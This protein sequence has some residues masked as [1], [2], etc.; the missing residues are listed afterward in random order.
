MQYPL[1]E[2]IGEPELFVGRK[3]EFANFNKWLANIP[4]KLSKSRAII[5]RRKSGK[6]AFVQRLFNQLWNENGAVIPFYFSFEENKIWYPDLAIKY[7]CA[8]ASQYISFQER[9]PKWVN[10]PLSLEE[11]KEY[12]R[13]NSNSLLIRDTRFIEQ[14]RGIGGNHSL[15]WDI[16]CSAPHRFADFF[17]Q[18]I[19]VILD[20]FQYI[21]QFVYPDKDYKNAPIET[22]AGSYH[23]LSESKIAPMLITGSYAGLLLSI[24]HEY[25]EA[26]RVKQIHFSPY[27]TTDEGLQAVYKYA[28]FYGEEIT[29]ETAV[30]INELCLADPFF[31][32]CVIQSEYAEKNLATQEGVIN[33]VNYEIS[34]SKAEMFL[35]WGEYLEKTL[36]R[37]NNKN[38][39]QLLLYLNKHN[40]RYWTPQQLKDKIPLSLSV[41]E[42]QKELMILSKIDV[43]ERGSSFIDFRGLQD[44]TL[45]LVLRRCFEKE[46]KGFAPNFPKEF[47]GIIEK[48]QTEN[49]S[50]RG[51]LSYYTGIVGEHLLATAFRNK[52]RFMLSDFFEN[53]TDTTKL[54][55]TFVRER[56]R[57]QR[58]NGKGLEI[59][60]VA[61]SDC[62]RVILVEVKKKKV[63]TGFEDLE[64]FLEKVE[65][66]K[67]LFPEQIVLPAFLSLGDFTKKAK[68]YCLDMGIGMAVEIKHV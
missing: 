42:I 43:I 10:T 36:D 16:V 48:L 60:L 26:G 32:Y 9:Q 39:K 7:Y 1:S 23:S 57:L 61:E 64:D 2:K 51:K 21:T 67:Q 33:T 6:T 12:G 58:E 3:T 55:I 40:A 34:D 4:R 62:G 29:N 46:I 49:R 65:I 63:K 25:L 31:I 56:F 14:N 44:G 66:Y 8:F 17:E 24:I 27:L 37:I 53:V 13:K 11:I 20:E 30:Q 5:A 45:N 54:N 41:D 22:L 15:M 59:D 47:S 18:Q 35:T 38:A 52:K 19:L 50:L 68:Q 28:Q